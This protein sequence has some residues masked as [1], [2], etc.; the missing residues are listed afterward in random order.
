MHN[1]R[2]YIGSAAL[3]LMAVSC[4]QEL[5][6]S[7][8][9]PAEGKVYSAVIAEETR[10][11]ATIDGKTAKFSWD[12]GDPVTIIDNEGRTEQKTIAVNAAGATFTTTL[13]SPKYA[14][15]PQIAKITDGNLTAV[16]LPSVYDNYTGSTNAAMIADISA[17]TDVANFRHIG[18]AIK[19]SLSNIPERCNKFEFIASGRK[20]TGDFRI[21]F[22][23]YAIS[24]EESETEN[25]V[26]FNFSADKS[27]RDFFVP[28]PVGTYNGFTV[29]LYYEGGGE[30]Y[31]RTTENSF[32]VKRRELNNFPTLHFGETVL[33]FTLKTVPSGW[34]T[35]SSPAK[36]SPSPATF[37]YPLDGVSYDFIIED[38]SPDEKN[39]MRILYN[40]NT[41]KANP[42]FK[43]PLN[44]YLGL[45][46]IPGKKLS[47]VECS[48]A[49]SKGS[50]GD[51]NGAITAQIYE[52]NQT[53]SYI[54]GG[55]IAAIQTPDT[56][57]VFNLKGTN[58]NTRYYLVCTENSDNKTTTW[59][60]LNKLTLTYKGES[61]KEDP[62]FV[63][64]RVGSFNLRVSGMDTGS[65]NEWSK[66]KERVIQS[67]KDNDFDFFGVQEVTTEQQ[68]YLK[69]SELKDIYEMK[70]FSPYSQ[71]GNGDKAQGLLYKKDKYTLSDWKFFWPSDNPE[72]MSKNDINGNTK[73]SRGSCCGI[74]T[75]K[76]NGAKMFMMVMHGML[77]D[78]AGDKYAYVN[79]DME[80]KYNPKGYPA[81]FVGD[82]NAVP[83][84][85]AYKTWT[86]HWRDAY[87]AVGA[88]NRTGPIGT[89]NGWK[90][91]QTAFPDRIDYIFFKGEATPLN[92]VCNDTKY[93]N[94]FP[95]DHF[96]LYS[97]F[98][99]KLI[100]E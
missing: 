96:P 62:S 75:D 39:N 91:N 84:R 42:Y 7:E 9:K 78:T 36:S 52:A 90:T 73:Y 10:S 85:Q 34:P 55:E 43:M 48:S 8:A 40:P 18:G 25:T 41:S 11:S 81:F 64:V 51:R 35:V 57:T 72:V 21:D 28:V 33:E 5:I 61:F 17:S 59:L 50:T 87:E 89:H 71:D 60:G 95:S 15:Y 83:T 24:T 16:S 37:S 77:D 30:C 56:P 27:D 12:N 46:V 58:A 100:A 80:K 63:K 67:I 3:C 65:V 22:E 76:T 13:E 79:N 32:E 66:R 99:V 44:T 29:K 20:I 26:T 1:T 19:I 2:K 4:Q 68:D 38:V 69:A 74:L 45:P 88:E 47:K 54:E 86:T 82:L 14:T 98:I 93:D 70:F 97:D 23:N 92:Y 49:A 31:S 6:E 94:L 53:K